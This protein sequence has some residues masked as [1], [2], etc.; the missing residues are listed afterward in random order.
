MIRIELNG[1]PTA[2]ESPANLEELLQKL[3]LDSANLAI[4][5]NQQV[6]PRSQRAETTLKDGDRVEIIR[7]VAGG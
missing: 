5:V 4:A 6:I 7:A 2:L 3:K 1:E